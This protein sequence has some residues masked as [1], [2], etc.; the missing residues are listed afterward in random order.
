MLSLKGHSWRNDAAVAF[1]AAPVAESGDEELRRGAL[2]EPDRRN[3]PWCGA[4]SSAVWDL[5]RSG[6]A[7]RT[8]LEDQEKARNRFA[9]T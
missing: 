8:L 7:V 5:T 3:H 6:P 2:I 4:I 1:D 9:A